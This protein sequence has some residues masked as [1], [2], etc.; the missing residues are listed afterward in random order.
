MTAIKLCGIRR[1]EEIELINSLKPEYAGFVFWDKSRRYIK[2]AAAAEL[3]N[4]LDPSIRAVGVFVDEE[5]EKVA[6]LLNSGTIDMAQLH[7]KEDEE[8][9]KR[10]RSMASKPIIKAFRIK[11][12]EDLKAAES[13]SAE[14]L[15]LDAGAGDGAVFDW[16]WLKAFGRPY[17]LA[18]GLNTENVAEAV[19]KL[20]PY[21]V[22]VSSGIETEGVKDKIKMQTFV[23]T[24]RR[25]G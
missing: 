11:A 8:Y 17:I 13:C 2:A 25:I 3:K 24:V 16:S 4:R 6:E 10:L 9:I 21:G 15:L 19:I 1:P 23:E 18:G 7:G 22:D 20:K 14:F 5:S 12:E